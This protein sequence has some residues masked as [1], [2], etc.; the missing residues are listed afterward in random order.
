MDPPKDPEVGFV[1]PRE[2]VFVSV[3]ALPGDRLPT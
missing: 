2:G 1:L 3:D